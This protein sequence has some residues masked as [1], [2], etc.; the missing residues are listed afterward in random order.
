[1]GGCSSDTLGLSNTLSEIV[2]SVAMAVNGP[3]EVISSEDML[4]Q[5]QKCNQKLSELR[6]QKSESAGTKCSKDKLNQSQPNSTVDSGG[7]DWRNEYI[8]LGTDVTALF[9]SLSAS[10]TAK[11]VRRQIEKSSIVWKN[12]DARWLTLYLK[13]FESNMNTKNLKD[14]NHLLPTRISKM[15]RAPSFGSY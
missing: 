3:Y 7:L 2:E 13:L 15:G 12:I 10:N 8:L 6:Q 1:M 4:S 9:P 14:I 5:I 11:S